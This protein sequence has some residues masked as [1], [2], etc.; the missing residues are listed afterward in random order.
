MSETTGSEKSLSEELSG[1]VAVVT[2]AASG[3]GA[4][5][6]RKLASAG[7]AVVCAD[8]NLDGANDLAFELS[9]DGSKAAAIRLDVASLKEWQ[10]LVTI[11]QDNFGSADV[12]ANCA[13]IASFSPAETISEDE[14]RK[15]HAVNL[16]GP[17]FG[18][19]ALLP[20]L[21]Q[22]DA[23]AIVNI[24]SLSAKIGA[25]YGIAYSSSKAGLVAVTKAAAKYFNRKRYN[26]RCN[27][28]LPGYVDTPLLD[29]FFEDRTDPAAARKKA[30]NPF[31]QGRAS[32][33]EEIA[34][35]VLFLASA[36]SGNMTGSEL[37]MDGGVW[38]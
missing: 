26:C 37:V 25:T 3:I 10:E 9:P 24:S 11:V 8:L 7:A 36:R 23:G 29:S 27:V 17:L 5:V 2:G 12:L 34:E 28:I 18:I 38:A 20:L 30:L 14:W 32:S 16:D 22:S 6:A 35:A 1:K 31:Y 4:A 13:G 21:K 33:A 19:Q 15:V